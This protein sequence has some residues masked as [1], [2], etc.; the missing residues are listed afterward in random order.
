MSLPISVNVV[1]GDEAAGRVPHPSVRSEVLF[2]EAQD[3]KVR[4][5]WPLS[6]ASSTRGAEAYE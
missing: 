3:L 6:G 1:P 2:Q 4:P 5:R